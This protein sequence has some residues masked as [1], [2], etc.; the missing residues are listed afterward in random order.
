LIILQSFL[1]YNAKKTFAPQRNSI[2]AVQKMVCGAP[3][4]RLN[5]RIA[6]F[7][8]SKRLALIGSPIQG[9]KTGGNASITQFLKD[10]QIR[11]VQEREVVQGRKRT[12]MMKKHGKNTYKEISTLSSEA[13]IQPV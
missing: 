9:S 4:S 5:L 2:A 10:T 13:A 12:W 8:S 11:A 7:Y 3:F 1:L 6:S